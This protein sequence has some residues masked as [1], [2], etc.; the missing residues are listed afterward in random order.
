MNTSSSAELH[1][2]SSSRAAP[3]TPANAPND[4]PNAAADAPAPSTG[5]SE[6]T[7][8]AE[9][10]QVVPTG[11][12]HQRT[13][14]TVATPT[15]PIPPSA[16]REPVGSPT[17][18]ADLD[19]LARCL[20]ALLGAAMPIV[21]IPGGQGAGSPAE[22]VQPWLSAARRAMR[23]LAWLR[24]KHIG[25]GHVLV[26]L[27]AYVR[28]G[29]EQRVG[30]G[31][32]GLIRSALL[33]P[34]MAR[35]AAQGRAG[36][37]L[38]RRMVLAAED[39]YTAAGELDSDGR[40]LS[41][42]LDELGRLLARNTA[43]RGGAPR[44]TAGPAPDVCATLPRPAEDVCA[45]ERRGGRVNAS[46]CTARALG[47]RVGAPCRRRRVDRWRIVAGV[48]LPSE[49]SGVREGRVVRGGKG[50]AWELLLSVAEPKR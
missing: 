25:Y 18:G 34:A 45:G 22:H 41:T 30:D 42:D 26:L 33:P 6:Q 2:E 1:A 24:S 14:G 43:P 49:R 15:P 32:F 44:S 38:G 17:V 36:A 11:T 46:E 12:H 19:A 9:V 40:W 20:P 13:S 50:T 10:T 39:A 5:V 28:L 37:A 47:R 21:R 3:T 27:Y 48:L 23:R 16:P 29:P 8:Q 31:W 35:T 7:H 4:A